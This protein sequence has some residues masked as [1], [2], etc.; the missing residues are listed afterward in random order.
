MDHLKTPVIPK[1]AHRI[2]LISIAFYVERIDLA[3]KLRKLD[4][5]WRD[6]SFFGK[7]SHYLISNTDPSYLIINKFRHSKHLYSL[8]NSKTTYS[9]PSSLILQYFIFP[10]NRDVI[11]LIG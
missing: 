6:Q 2:K 5:K 9:A 11:A 10:Q 4:L 8:Q 7:K 1:K 3:S